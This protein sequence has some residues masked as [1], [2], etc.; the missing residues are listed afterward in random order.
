[1][2]NYENDWR[3]R[4]EET[5]R[6]PRKESKEALAI[7]MRTLAIWIGGLI[8]SAIIG[9]LIASRLAAPAYDPVWAGLFLG[10]PA[11]ML[12]FACIRLWFSK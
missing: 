5:Y 9:V 12:S 1:M 10:V 8:A 6:T 2:K 11:G 3:K 4:L 7:S